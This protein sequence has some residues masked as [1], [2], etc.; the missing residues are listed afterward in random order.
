MDFLK[1]LFNNDALTYDEFK[2]ALEA[3][4]I[5]LADLSKGDYVSKR[6]YDDDLNAKVNEITTLNEALSRRDTDL[7]GLRVKLTEAGNDTDKLTQLT[8]DFT[9]L[10]GKY[11]TDVKNYKAMLKKQAYEFAVK[12]FAAGQKFTSNAAKR[13]FIN[14]MIS[15]DLKMG[16][17]GIL[18]G[19]DFV[20]QYTANN[21][22][23]FVRESVEREEPKPMFIT[24]SVPEQDQSN[25]FFTFN[26]TGVRPH[27]D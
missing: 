9:Q 25:E 16:D 19:D 6:K 20:K 1:A 11:D 26:F 14:S 15:A 18:G 10:Q 17:A 22:D 2:T 27:E 13:D 12:E 23:A 24:P 4:N 3:N 7:E 5:K 8:N 21:E